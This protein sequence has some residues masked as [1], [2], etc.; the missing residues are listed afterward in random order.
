MSDSDITK[1]ETALSLVVMVRDERIGEKS[2]A[3]FRKI[4]GL[5]R[6]DDR[7][8]PSATA[9]MRGAFSSTTRVPHVDDLKVVLDFLHSSV[10][11]EKRSKF[12]D[13][14][15]YHSF[16]AIADSSDTASRRGLVRYDFTSPLFI[17][18][19]TQVLSNNNSKDHQGMALVVL[20]ELD[21]Q[22]FASDNAFLDPNKA[23][24]FVEAWWAAAEKCCTGDPQRVD[25]AAGQVFF[26]IVNSPH[27][28]VHIPPDA[29]DLVDN[30]HYIRDANPPSLQRCKQNADL[31]PFVKQTSPKLG[32][33]FWMVML[34]LEYHSLSNEVRDQMERE[35][36]ETISRERRVG[37][38]AARFSHTHHYKSW[39]SMLDRYLES[40]DTRLRDLDPSDQRVPSIR[41]SQRLVAEA[42][43]R[44]LEIKQEVKR[45]PPP[46]NQWWPLPH[47]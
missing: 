15:I 8:W 13:E 34:W 11:S 28:R 46:A 25:I 42:R 5:T 35:T 16:R 31:L 45:H 43:E 23:K 20:P 44:I 39:I 36:R 32:L 6:N 38:T 24:D 1:A 3:L 37:G 10:S 18:T 41:A 47:L 19:I 22:L 21:S 27:L 7:L 17:D 4:M 30:F 12:G 14:P 26:A 29:W 40:L 33:P 9:S 2:F